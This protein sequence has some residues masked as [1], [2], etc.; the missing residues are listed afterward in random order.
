ME[1]SQGVIPGL[2]VFLNGNGMQNRS[3]VLSDIVGDD[4]H[5]VPPNICEENIGISVGNHVILP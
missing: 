4:A 3:K 1:T 5:I 2:F